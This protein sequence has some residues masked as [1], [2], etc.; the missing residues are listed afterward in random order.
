[1]PLGGG[2]EYL[3]KMGVTAGSYDLIPLNG[4]QK[5]VAKRLTESHINVPDFPL[6][7]DCEID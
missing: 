6:N 5:V 3:T 1:M 7:I 4:I 2:A